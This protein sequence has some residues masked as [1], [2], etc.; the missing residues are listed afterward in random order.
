MLQCYF[1]LPSLDC[2]KS[3]RVFGFSFFYLEMSE[4][5]PGFIVLIKPSNF[6]IEK[7]NLPHFHMPIRGVSCNTEKGKTICS[8][9]M[10]MFDLMG[11]PREAYDLK[12]GEESNLEISSSWIQIRQTECVIFGMPERVRD[13]RRSSYHFLFSLFVAWNPLS[14]VM[15]IEQSFF[16]QMET[17]MIWY[18]RL[19]AQKNGR[20]YWLALKRIFCLTS[21]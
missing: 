1:K 21:S 10:I 6:N 12:R 9:I 19:K 2:C 14:Q 5:C 18:H 4:V 7:H 11:V 8:Q 16:K 13:L 3:E 17:S 20:L 15:Q